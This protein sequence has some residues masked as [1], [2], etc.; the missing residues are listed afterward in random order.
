MI[1][2]FANCVLEPSLV[3]ILT[4]FKLS[5]LL[6]NCAKPLNTFTLFFFNKWLIPE[7]NCEA[8][9]LERAVTLLIST[10][11]L[12]TL[13]PNSS[14]LSSKCLISLALNKAFVGMHPQFKQIPPRC[15][16]STS[17]TDIPN[18][19]ALIAAT[20]PP[21]PPPITIIS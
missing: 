3:L 12:E 7:D 15:L 8:T 14:T 1:I 21:G 10:L 13:K 4:F 2:F 5:L 17:A 16:S 18:C 20:Y 19:E 9:F 11:T 6:S